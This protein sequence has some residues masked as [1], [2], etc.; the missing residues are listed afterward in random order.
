MKKLLQQFF[1]ISKNETPR[2]GVYNR[3][4]LGR[5]ARLSPAPSYWA[6]IPVKPKGLFSSKQQK[7]FAGEE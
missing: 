3:N 6:L 5:A 7:P 2:P 4:M 1:R